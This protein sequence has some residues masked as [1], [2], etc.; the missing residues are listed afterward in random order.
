MNTL[1]REFDAIDTSVYWF[2]MND[3]HDNGSFRLPN[4][5]KNSINK[6]GPPLKVETGDLRDFLVT[7]VE[8]LIEF[9]STP[10]DL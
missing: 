8:G 6:P 9:E 5:S 3:H 1:N 7:D 4:Q 10:P 2:D